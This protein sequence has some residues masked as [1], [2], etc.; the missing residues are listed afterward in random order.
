MIDLK[1]GILAKRVN[2][3][4]EQQ[5]TLEVNL[6]LFPRIQL[7]QK[8]NINKWQNVGYYLS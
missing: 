8:L 5:A 1:V 4:K 3:I 2:F 7:T 6:K